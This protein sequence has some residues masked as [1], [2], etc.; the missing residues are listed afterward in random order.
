MAA[1]ERTKPAAL[2]AYVG[3]IDVSI[4]HVTDAIAH[5]P[6]P[7]IVGQEQQALERFAL[8]RKKRRAVRGSQFVSGRRFVEDRFQS[9]VVITQ[10]PALVTSDRSHL[11]T[12]ARVRRSAPEPSRIRADTW[13]N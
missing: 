7:Q 6:A 13:D 8:G 2:H 5:T 12:P 3:E 10:A 11:S 9:H 4:H 1:A